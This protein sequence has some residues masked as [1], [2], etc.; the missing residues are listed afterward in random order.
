MINKKE[1]A[2]GW[3]D[4]IANGGGF[5]VLEPGDYPFC[6]L[7]MMRGTFQPKGT[8]S[9]KES[10]P[11]A[12]LKIEVGGAESSITIDHMLILHTKTTGFL[13]DFFVSIGQKK[14]DEAFRPN[15]GAIGGASGVCRIVK[16]EFTMKT[17]EIGMKNKIAKFLPP[18]AETY[19][20]PF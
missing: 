7:S 13:N 10:C 16:E 2:Y 17:G 9:I 4:E 5:T 6:V 20:K 15:W 14:G 12:T 11:M 19:E 18:S 8:G 1:G 3:D